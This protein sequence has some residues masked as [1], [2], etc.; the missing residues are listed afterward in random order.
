MHGLVASIPPQLP[1]LHS[2]LKPTST[3]AATLLLNT[4]SELASSVMELPPTLNCW[5]TGSQTKSAEV[6]C[7]EGGG[8]Q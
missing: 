4:P 3:L 8:S 7:A 5:M 2:M 6:Q 1:P